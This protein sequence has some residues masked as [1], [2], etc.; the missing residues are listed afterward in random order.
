ML[1]LQVTQDLPVRWGE[2]GLNLGGK[3]VREAAQ[4]VGPGHHR[5]AEVESLSRQLSEQD[6]PAE[7]SG[8][9]RLQALNLGTGGN[10]GGRFAG[11]IGFGRE[12]IG[13]TQDDVR[14]R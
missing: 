10:L 1:A 4:G 13:E 6:A 7:L 11:G 8:D 2:L 9:A 5:L 3:L 12:R 14:L